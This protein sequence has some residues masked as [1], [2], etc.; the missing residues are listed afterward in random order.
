MFKK[1]LTKSLSKAVAAPLPF[2]DREVIDALVR[3]NDADLDEFRRGIEPLASSG[4]L[5]VLLAQFP[6]SFK[7]D[8]PSRD[9]V[10]DLLRALSDYAVAVELRH[11]SWSDSVAETLTL[12]G[13]F[14][15]G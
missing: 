6:P 3:P 2:S 11:R 9:Y 1:S 5:G 14:G 8:E 10:A 4:K 7:N 12:L 13:G 15:A